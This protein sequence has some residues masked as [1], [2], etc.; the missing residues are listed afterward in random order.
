MR[1]HVAG[2]LSSLDRDRMAPGAEPERVIEVPVRTLDDILA[3]ACAPR[4]SICCRSTSRVTSS[5]CSAASIFARWRPRLILI[6][7]HVGNLDK[8]RFLKARGYRLIRRCR[9]QRLVR[10]A[11][12]GSRGRLR[13]RW[14]ILRK[15]YLALPFRIAA[16]RVAAAAP[17]IQWLDRAVERLRCESPYGVAC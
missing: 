16:Q 10:S 9:E 13:E 14:E 15:Y 12:R 2:A 3:E 8:H 7:D 11:R 4:R 6:E 5:K 1:L 17:A